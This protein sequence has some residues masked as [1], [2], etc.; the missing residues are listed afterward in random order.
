MAWMVMRQ[1]YG[2]TLRVV[3]ESR[4]SK[5]IAA[6]ADIL[7]DNSDFTTLA[8][9]LWIL[10]KLLVMKDSP[11][12]GG[13]AAI[14]PSEMS[15]RLLR[16]IIA[17]CYRKMLRR[18]N[19][20]T[21]SRPYFL[22][23]KSVED[24]TFNESLRGQPSMLETASDWLFLENVVLDGGHTLR[25][26]I[27]HIL[28]QANLAVANQNFQ[29]YNQNTCK[30]FH[31]L[32]LEFLERFQTS[33]SELSK[34]R[35]PAKNVPANEQFKQSLVRVLLNG[36]ALQRIAKGTA[37]RMHLRTIEAELVD[38]CRPD[39]STPLPGEDAEKEGEEQDKRDEELEAVQ[40]YTVS[41]ENN[42]PV[43]L[44]LWKAYQNCYDSLY[45]L[46]CTLFSFLSLLYLLY[47]TTRT[48]FLS[49]F[50]SLIVL[51]LLS[52]PCLHFPLYASYCSL[53]LTS[54]Y[55]NTVVTTLF[56]SQNLV[57]YTPILFLTR[58]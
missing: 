44:P 33:V 4:G 31:F 27:P 23:L 35:G 14:V 11:S 48:L 12:D 39:M 40:P 52:F 24:V 25:T 50:T 15:N 5:L 20:N 41:M 42:R 9:H 56:S 53:Y 43:P 58:P 49:M 26:P 45:F 57:E 30:E 51:F 2:L 10:S 1:S 21:L 13:P 6:H 54:Y 29:L 55:L 3:G 34:H 18:L 46:L 8:D 17:T 36:F 19:H 47:S 38:H 16:Y 7:Y 22:S 37:L 28:E 32:F